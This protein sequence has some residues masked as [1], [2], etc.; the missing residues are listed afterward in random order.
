MVVNVKKKQFRHLKKISKEHDLKK[1][2]P[3]NKNPPPKKKKVLTDKNWRHL[4]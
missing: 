4:K 3:R 2:P 1:N